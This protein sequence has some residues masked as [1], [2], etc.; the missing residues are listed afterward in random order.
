MLPAEL[1]E[2]APNDFRV[3]DRAEMD[4]L[5]EDALTDY[6]FHLKQAK[7][8]LSKQPREKILKLQGITDR[9][10]PTIAGLML[11]GEYPQAFFPQLGITA[12]SVAGTSIGDLGENGE[13][14]IDNQRIEGTLVQ[15]LSGALSFVKRNMRIA[16]VITPEGRRDDREEYPLVAVREIILNALIH[17][18]YSIHTDQSPIRVILYRDRLEVENPGGLYGR[19]TLDNLGKA[20]ADTRNPYIA[21]ALEVIGATENR[22]SGIPTIKAEMEKAGLP[23]A[24]FES[25]RGI[26]KVTLYNRFA[27]NDEATTQDSGNLEDKILAFCSVPRSRAEIADYLGI[28]TS[29][30]VSRKYIKPLLDS[31]KLS[32]TLPETPKSKNQR[33]VTAQM[34]AL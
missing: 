23:P 17:R 6:C 13:R 34:Q 16:T 33:Y 24:V 4:A 2:F 9:D 29:S 31:G 8:N 19:M 12:M 1:E 22:F 30:Y 7:P 5:D 25:A 26:F 3:V 20:A 32:E 27:K 28:E 10:K 14:F 21:G 11:F 18:D 15:M